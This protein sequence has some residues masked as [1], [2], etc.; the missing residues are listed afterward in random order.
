[1]VKNFRSFL[2]LIVIFVGSVA[3]AGA[4][5]KWLR[6]NM[7]FI[8]DVQQDTESLAQEVFNT[9]DVYFVPAFK[10]LYAPY[11]RKDARGC[12]SFRNLQ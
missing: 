10:G 1:M 3:V 11:W 6:D 8:K 4:A 12:V 2:G 9:G 5:M 7:G